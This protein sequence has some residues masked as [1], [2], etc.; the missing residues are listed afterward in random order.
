MWACPDK[1]RYTGDYVFAYILNPSPEKERILN[2]VC[3]RLKMQVYIFSD[4]ECR[5]KQYD[6]KWNLEVKTD[7]D[8]PEWLWALKN[9]SYVITDSFH[10]TCFATIFSKDFISIV[11]R[12]RGAT[13]FESI[14]DL[15]REKD[16]MV[17]DAID[18]DRKKE[19]IID[20]PVDYQYIDTVLKNERERCSKWLK[21]C[22]SVAL[23]SKKV[24]A[25]YDFYLKHQKEIG[26]IGNCRIYGG[27]G[28][29]GLQPGC[30]V[31]DIINKLPNNSGIHQ[32][33]GAL[34][35]P[36]KDTPVAYG[37]LEIYRG[38]DYFIKVIFSQMTIEGKEP[39]IY[40]GKVKNK[41]IVSWE[42]YVTNSEYVALSDRVKELEKDVEF[43]LRKY[44]KLL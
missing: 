24:S 19:L 20:K 4:V 29:L 17:E 9:S 27:I 1:D 43:L 6:K 41:R 39:Q 37:I 7:A 42:R 8:L 23:K 15:F 5:V 36:I 11:N 33:Q 22:I 40:Q 14:L 12:R 34:G 2:Q 31:D 25:T 26:K 13:R 32:V 28:E 3:D 44:V 10:G 21:N 35:E 38:T 16:R 30:T 18:I